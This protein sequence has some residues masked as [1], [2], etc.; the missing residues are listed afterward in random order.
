MSN[1]WYVHMHCYNKTHTFSKLWSCMYC[2]LHTSSCAMPYDI[3]WN[4]SGNFSTHKVSALCVCVCV[5]FRIP[6]GVLL[7]C[8]EVCV[9]FKKML[10]WVCFKLSTPE[11]KLVQMHHE[12]RELTFQRVT[13]F[14]LHAWL[15]VTFIRTMRKLREC[16]NNSFTVV[17]KWSLHWVFEMTVFFNIY[18]M[19]QVV[20]TVVDL[21][22]YKV[23]PSNHF[24]VMTMWQCVKG[25]LYLQPTENHQ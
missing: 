21:C 19:L 5:L 24:F 7:L 16:K 18:I 2:K 14:I 3:D 6:S 10:K 9:R 13:P 17:N 12:F 1:I 4:C 25:L 22:I 8:K 20:I 23:C 11:Q 15:N